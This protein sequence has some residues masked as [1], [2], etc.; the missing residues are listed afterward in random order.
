MFD[1]VPGYLRIFLVKLSTV[2]FIWKKSMFFWNQVGYKMVKGMFTLSFFGFRQK[3][4][5][6][7]FHLKL[8]AN[9]VIWQ[10]YENPTEADSE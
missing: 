1:K 4:N 9:R 5:Q 7:K 10:K 8:V 6:I 2:S 3:F